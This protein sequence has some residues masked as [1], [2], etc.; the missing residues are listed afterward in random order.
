M[1]EP[2]ICLGHLTH[3]DICTSS[4]EPMPLTGRLLLVKKNAGRIPVPPKRDSLTLPP[5]NY[6]LPSLQCPCTEVTSLN[7]KSDKI[8]NRSIVL[9]YPLAM[10]ITFHRRYKVIRPLFEDLPSHISRRQRISD[11]LFRFNN[12]ALIICMHVGGEGWLQAYIL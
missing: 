10:L 4:S 2:Y 3:S 8:T 9:M 7:D 6:M 12:G 1:R 11:S 5:R